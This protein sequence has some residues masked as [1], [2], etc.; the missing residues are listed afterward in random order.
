MSSEFLSRNRLSNFSNASYSSNHS[1]GSHDN[2]RFGQTVIGHDYASNIRVPDLAIRTTAAFNSAISPTSTVSMNEASD[3]DE[4]E[5]NHDN[6]KKVKRRVTFNLDDVQVQTIPI[7]SSCSSSDESSESDN[8]SQEDGI[9]SPPIT[10]TN[11]TTNQDED[12]D[13]PEAIPPSS[14]PPPPMTRMASTPLQPSST[15]TISERISKK[16]S[17]DALQQRKQIRRRDNS[18]SMLTSKPG[19]WYPLSPTSTR[20]SANGGMVRYGS[21]LPTLRSLEMT[22]RL[23]AESIQR[24]MALNPNLLHHAD[25]KKNNYT[26][27]ISAT[28]TTSTTAPPKPPIVNNDAASMLIT[29][30]D[31]DDDEEHENSQRFIEKEA[32]NHHDKTGVAINDEQPNM[33]HSPESFSSVL[34]DDDEEEEEEGEIDTSVTTSSPEP[35][36]NYTEDKEQVETDFTNSVYN[37]LAKRHNQTVIPF[38]EYEPPKLT[39]PFEQNLIPISANGDVVVLPPPQNNN[40]PVCINCS[41][42]VT[43][44]NDPSQTRSIFFVKVLRAENLDFPIDNDNTSIYCSIRY[45]T[46]ENRSYDQKMAHTMIIDHEMRIQDVDPNEQIAITIHVAAT[47]NNKRLQHANSSWYHRMKTP[48]DL[49]RYVHEKD[50]SICQ[51]LFSPN[52]FVAEDALDQTASLMLVNNWYR[53]NQQ[54]TITSSSSLLLRRTSTLIKKKSAISTPAIVREKAVGK[55]YVQCL[56]LKIKDNY[57]PRDIDEAVEALN[58]KRFHNTDW[59]SGYLSQLGGNAKHLNRRFFKLTGGCLFA[60][61]DGP[62]KSEKDSQSS[63]YKIPLWRATRL[64]CDNLIVIERAQHQSQTTNP[65]TLVSQLERVIMLDDDDDQDEETDGK[66]EN[67]EKNNFQLVFD[68]GDKIYFGC[69]SLEERNKWVSVI[70]IIICR[71]PPLPDWIMN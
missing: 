68:N 58:A 11:T 46:R 52:R 23:I 1:N 2:N 44:V 15:E 10:I 8:S 9:F 57:I 40:D 16:A 65:T 59:Q 34:I 29:D 36:V 42:P 7:Y 30:T 12:D 61:L 67:Q 47:Q 13:A 27:D 31:S 53:T 4:Q 55:I 45:K 50:G 19:Y 24:E 6:G 32:R 20:S 51:T 21:P 64:I 18:N 26:Q 62:D 48:S 17:Y 66:A 56:Y 22:E 38:P 25:A 14:P 69:E 5:D 63:L 70:E 71:L 43:A 35:R 3:A 60:Y 54:A 41:S 49:Q 39:F 33:R 28:S 37:E